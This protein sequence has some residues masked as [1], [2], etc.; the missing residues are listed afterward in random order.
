MSTQ[1]LLVVKD[2]V[3]GTQ[4]FRYEG[5]SPVVIA[6]FLPAYFFEGGT[7]EVLRS[8]KVV[9]T[10]QNIEPCGDA[11]LVAFHSFSRF[12]FSGI[13]SEN[14]KTKWSLYPWEFCSGDRLVFRRVDRRHIRTSMAALKVYLDSQ[15]RSYIPG[16]CPP[17][18]FFISDKTSSAMSALLQAPQFTLTGA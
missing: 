5:T 4:M 11:R 3:S 13:G 8:G 17:R 15:P 16:A 6:A 9:N 1:S 12:T 14:L 7:V 10:C 18:E 2:E